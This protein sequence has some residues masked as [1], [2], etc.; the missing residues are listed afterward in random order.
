MIFRISLIYLMNLVYPIN[1][2]NPASDK[3]EK[4]I[5]ENGRKQRQRKYG[6]IAFN[7]N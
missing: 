5:K 4:T 7:G 2:V 1:S 3:K 6:K